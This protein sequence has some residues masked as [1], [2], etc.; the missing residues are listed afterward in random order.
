M[1]SFFKPAGP[2]RDGELTSA[3]SALEGVAF[4]EPASTNVEALDMAKKLDSAYSSISGADRDFQRYE[5][6]R[7]LNIANRTGRFIPHLDRIVA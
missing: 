7:S 3:D 1:P 6:S 2:P 4:P 5:G